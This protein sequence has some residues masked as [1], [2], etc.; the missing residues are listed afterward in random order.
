MIV[1]FIQLHK[2]TIL[3]I[4]ERDNVVPYEHCEGDDPNSLDKIIT[5]SKGRMLCFQTFVHILERG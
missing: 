1:R 2:L 4:R 5:T 3:T